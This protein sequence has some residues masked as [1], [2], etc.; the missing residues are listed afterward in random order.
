MSKFN[1][2]Q[3]V[4]YAAFSSAG[5]FAITHTFILSG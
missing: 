1:Y 4:T 3:D 5:V 2:L